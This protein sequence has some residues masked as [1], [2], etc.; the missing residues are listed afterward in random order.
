MPKII[1]L[2]KGHPARV[3]LEKVVA[4]NNKTVAPTYG[5]PIGPVFLNAEEQDVYSV[6]TS[7][8]IDILPTCVNG[9]CHL[10]NKKGVDVTVEVDK[11]ASSKVTDWHLVDPTTLQDIDL[12]QF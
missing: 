6:L 4:S 3:E 8:K 10:V 5:K 1:N 12:G 9:V 11:E 2:P 7:H